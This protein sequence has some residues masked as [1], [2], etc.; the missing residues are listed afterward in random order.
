MPSQKRTHPKEKKRLHPRNK[1]RERYD[2]PLL[3]GS[4]PGL[5][6]FVRINKFNDE[7]ID[8]SD[9]AA[10]KML[11]KAL[12]KH[13][14]RIDHWD[15][16]ANYLCPPIPGRADYVH[17]LA[18]LLAGCNGG[19]IPMGPQIHCL[20][21]GVGANCIYPV[22]GH[23]EYGWSFAGSDID[24]VSI[25]FAKNIVE[26]NDTLKGA[27]DLRLQTNPNTIFS[28][29]MKEDERFDL[30]LC[31][32]PFHSSAEEARFAAN[33]KVTNLNLKKG[34]NPTLNFGGQSNELWCPGGEQSFIRDMIHQ[35]KTFA[36]SCFWFTSLVSRQTT[37]KTLYEALK[38]MEVV[39]AKTIPMG[40]GNKISR[41]VAWTFLSAEKRKSWI[42]ARWRS[43]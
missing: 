11:N 3:T 13:F 38:Q 29:I 25:E 6:T 31:N 8:F 28:G 42:T 16:P 36:D 10:V 1:H 17:Y 40:Q 30:T 12:L 37:L 4:C 27:V 7:S 19:V 22:I 9:P 26:S 34:A 18:D 41:M 15:I 33:R 23:R 2:F 24:P 21:I 35:S 43:E 39:E 5:L 14:Y 20:D 32:P